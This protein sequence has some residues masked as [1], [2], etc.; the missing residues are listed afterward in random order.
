MSYFY[1][2]GWTSWRTEVT[3]YFLDGPHGGPR[4]K[5]QFEVT[6][7]FLDHSLERQ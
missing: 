4:R 3:F 2:F 1:F 6:F 7:I 5:N